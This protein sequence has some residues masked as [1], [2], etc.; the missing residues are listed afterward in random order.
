VTDSAEL[1]GPG[2]TRREYYDGTPF[3]NDLPA[4]LAYLCR[5]ATG[6]PALWWMDY[7][8]R[9]YATPP[10]RCGLVVGCGNGW[11]ERDLY[12]RGV[13]REFD[14]FDVSP[15][16]VEQASA[17][18]GGRPLRYFH[19][20]FRHFEPPRRYDLIVNVA[21]LHH[22]KYLHRLVD[23]LASALT[24]DGIFVNWDYVGPDRNQYG[25][26]QVGLMEETN[27]SL[28][29]RFR[30]TGR[31]RWSIRDSIADDPTEAVHASE[32]LPV[33]RRRFQ[34]LEEHPLG[35]GIAYQ[36]L[37]NNVREFARDDPEA[38]EWMQVCS[39][40]TRS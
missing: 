14:A 29:E 12:D 36:L 21:A 37:W 26:A 27:R 40:P 33:M 17:A 8:K 31:L 5:R 35:G 19:A 13:A 25:A 28:P 23:V 18:A 34:M 32:I 24:P 30:S 4:V 2:G 10:R 7:V 38:R 22:A 16:Y 39:R 9:R 15:A 1:C 6:D 3:W 11:V 20:D